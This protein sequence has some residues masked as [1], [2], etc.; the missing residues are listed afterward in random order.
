MSEDPRIPGAAIDWTD[1]MALA[2]FGAPYRE[3]NET[4]QGEV[5][6]WMCK[7]LGFD[8]ARAYA[9]RDA[10]LALARL[11]TL[12]APIDEERYVSRRH[13]GFVGAIVGAQVDGT[14]DALDRLCDT[15][16]PTWHDE[17]LSTPQIVEAVEGVEQLRAVVRRLRSLSVPT[18]RA[19]WIGVAPPY[20]RA[21]DAT[22]LV[23]L[24]LERD[25]GPLTDRQ[26]DLLRERLEHGRPFDLNEVLTPD[27][28]GG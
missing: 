4:G 7:D 2:L 6:V 26:A 1:R 9:I 18:L 3:L 15:L 13:I 17:R 19:G 10:H 14:P 11:L 5:C 24:L 22:E 27:G 23:A 8:L 20:P 12:F 28:P 21:A 16:E 25:R